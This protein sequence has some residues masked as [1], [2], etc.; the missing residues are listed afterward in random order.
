MKTIPEIC[1]ET[2]SLKDYFE[3]KRDGDVIAFDAIEADLNIKMDYTGKQHMRSA[4]RS[5]QREYA[6]IRG[7]G[8]ELSSPANATSLVSH[9]LIKIDNAVK[10][11]ERAAKRCMH[12]IDD[13][14]AEDSKNM[15]FVT[16]AFGAIRA[17]A[18]LYRKQYRQNKE[19]ILKVSN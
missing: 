14:T 11:G 6:A 13:M 9:R 19:R 2:K 1:E 5:L 10:R 12:F 3:L 17:S 4:L 15:L 18:N 8:I 7:Y 16:S